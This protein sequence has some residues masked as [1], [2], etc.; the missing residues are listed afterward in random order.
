MDMVERQKSLLESPGIT[1]I[2]DALKN[3]IAEHIT[4]GKGRPPSLLI[5][6]LLCKLK[7]RGV[8]DEDEFQTFRKHISQKILDMITKIWYKETRFGL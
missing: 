8:P 5:H 7:K 6:C 4:K 1:L 3:V 2:W